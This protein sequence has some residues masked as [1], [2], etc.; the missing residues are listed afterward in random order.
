MN[1]VRTSAI[2]VDLGIDRSLTV[3]MKNE[4]G[5]WRWYYTD[6]VVTVQPHSGCTQ[7]INLELGFMILPDLTFQNHVRY[8]YRGYPYEFRNQ[9]R[10][11]D[12]NFYFWCSSNEL[13]DWVE[14]YRK[15]I[16]LYYFTDIRFGVPRL[17]L[18]LLVHPKM[19]PPL[20]AS[21]PQPQPKT[22]KLSWKA[23]LSFPVS[24]LKFCSNSDHIDNILSSIECAILL[25]L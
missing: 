16:V 21:K 13:R 25:Q 9:L 8:L 14:L 11:W 24:N 6:T 4:A 20:S 7:R 1:R 5:P 3:R 2:T 17:L 22:V 23:L 19:R 18:V 12:L 10:I 15:A